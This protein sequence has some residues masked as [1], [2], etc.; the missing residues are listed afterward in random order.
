M[1]IIDWYKNAS[2]IKKAVTAGLLAV[3]LAVGTAVGSREFPRYFTDCE[4]GQWYTDYGDLFHLM[5]ECQRSKYASSTLKDGRKMAYSVSDELHSDC[6][7][8]S[9]KGL[10]NYF[11]SDNLC[12]VYVYG[13]S[14]S[15]NSEL[16]VYD[17]F[18]DGKLDQDGETIYVKGKQLSL[19]E[20][21]A[22]GPDKFEQVLNYARE[23]VY[24]PSRNPE[25]LTKKKAEREA[26]RSERELYEKLVEK[27]ELEEKQKKIDAIKEGLEDIVK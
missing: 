8:L 6:S 24:L 9:Q 23:K 17:C 14:W 1:K 5:S 13:A 3:T 16:S 25:V 12:S 27:T 15:S 21:K 7:Y 2:G 26:R 19:E 18:C 10:E 20:I 11:T 4:D 22:I